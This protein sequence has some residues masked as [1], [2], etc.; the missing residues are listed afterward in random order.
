LKIKIYT[1]VKDESYVFIGSDKVGSPY[2]AKELP[3]GSFDGV[4]FDV[5]GN[6]VTKNYPGH[7]VRVWEF[8]F[9]TFTGRTQCDLERRLT[10]YKVPGTNS[11]PSTLTWTTQVAALLM[12]DWIRPDTGSAV[13]EVDDNTVLDL[14]RSIFT[15]LML[16]ERLAQGNVYTD[17]EIEQEKNFSTANTLNT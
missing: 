11:Q 2:Y 9:K 6:P 8:T 4:E 3:D 13:I 16:D 17:V 5:Y 14:P 12:Q 7:I 10:S 1:T 15:G